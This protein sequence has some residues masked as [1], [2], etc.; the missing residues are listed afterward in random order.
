LVPWLNI[1]R[2]GACLGRIKLY[3]AVSC[4]TG[5][6]GENPSKSWDEKRMRKFRSLASGVGVTHLILSARYHQL[7]LR[8]WLPTPVGDVGRYLVGKRDLCTANYCEYFA[9]LKERSFR[10]QLAFR[11]TLAWDT[12]ACQR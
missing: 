6:S 4:Q 2:P 11:K 10:T 5:T 1:D 3:Q 7:G 8:R 12:A 9:A